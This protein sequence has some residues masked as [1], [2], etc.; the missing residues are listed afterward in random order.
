MN[1]SSIST[2]HTTQAVRIRNTTG[3]AQELWLEPLG[4]RVVLEPN[5]LY[6]LTA[7][8]ALEEIDLSVDGFTVYGWVTRIAAVESNGSVQTVW[9]LPVE[10]K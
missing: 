3:E 10:S 2:T 9:E 6:E 7:T 1:M 5:V 8:N 4:D